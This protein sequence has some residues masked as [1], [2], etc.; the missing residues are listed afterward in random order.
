MMSALHIVLFS[1]KQA[2]EQCWDGTQSVGNPLKALWDGK[3]LFKNKQ[4]V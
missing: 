3:R 2:Q 4:I 1:Q